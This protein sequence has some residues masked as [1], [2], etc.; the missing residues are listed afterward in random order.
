MSWIG[1]INIFKMSMLF[2]AISNKIP[3][4][5]FIELEQITLK[6]VWNHKIPRN[7]QCNLK[8]NKA[9]GVMVP[10]FKLLYKATIIKTV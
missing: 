8:K 3:M 9:G 10:D 7:S 5:F 2:S 4:T 1:R 6:F